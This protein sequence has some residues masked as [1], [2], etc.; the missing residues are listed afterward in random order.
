MDLQ[1]L[2]KANAE[3][4]RITPSYEKCRT[5]WTLADWSNALAGETGELCNLI[6]KIR[7]GDNIDSKEVGK[8]L[9]DIVIYA[10]L[11]ASQL[12]L[13]MSECLREKFNEVS[14]RV[15]CPIKI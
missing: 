9:A 4:L 15:H 7:R 12:G 2:S 5:E 14:D 11:L 3:R 13:D 6:K 8:E 10:D 1:I